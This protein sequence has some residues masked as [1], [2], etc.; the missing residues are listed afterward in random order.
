MP[1][2]DAADP[3]AKEEPYEDAVTKKAHPGDIRG[4]ITLQ[5]VEDATG[6]PVRFILQ[7]LGLPEDTPPQ[8]KRGRLRKKYGFSIQEVK[9]IVEK[10]QR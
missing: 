2:L 7:K 6:V 1:K 10:Y 5:E 4:A 3:L 9:D 8:E